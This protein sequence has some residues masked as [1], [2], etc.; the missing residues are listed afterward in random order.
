MGGKE[1]WP[2]FVF[3]FR[4][5]RCG[6]LRANRRAF[7]QLTRPASLP[8]HPQAELAEQ[9]KALDGGVKA[10]IRASLLSTLG[11]QVR[12]KRRKTKRSDRCPPRAFG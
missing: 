6:R 4:R 7:Y 12:E 2:G 3:V 5:R 1:R 8:T 10:Q 11:S 9:W